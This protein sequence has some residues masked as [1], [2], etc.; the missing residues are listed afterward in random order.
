MKE[1]NLLKAQLMTLLPWNQARIAFIAQFVLALLDART[2]NL[3]TL[4]LKF[5]TK[6]KP[7]S[8]Y[9]RIQRFLSKYLFDFDCFAQLIARLMPFGDKWVLCVDRTDWKFGQTPINLMVLGV[10]YKGVCIPL[11]WSFLP[12]KGCSN[13]KE[14]IHLIE[15]FL[16]LFG[17]DKIEY[18]TADREFIGHEW[19]NWL[20]RE[21]IPFRIRIRKNAQVRSARSHQLMNVCRLFCGNQFEQVVVLNKRREVMGVKVYIIGLRKADEYVILITDEKPHTA[22]EDYKRRWEIEMLF[23]CLKRRGFDFETTHVKDEVRVN[24]LLALLGLALCWCILQGEELC[25]N[26]ELKLKK[27]GYPAKSLFRHG[28]ESLT[29]LIA[30]ISFKFSDFRRAL[31]LLSCS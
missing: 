30:N 5:R 12:K 8:S 2:T 22:M 11:L 29:N 6:A 28:L 7:Q 23:S 10:A 14:R 17:R 25:K 13:T 4:A 19:I 31:K 24:K 1:H 26:K 20:Q 15:R 3:N 27:H 9:K 16:K 21:K 18:L